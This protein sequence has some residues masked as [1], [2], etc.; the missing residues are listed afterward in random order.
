MNISILLQGAKGSSTAG[1]PARQVDN[2]S[3][4]AAA[5]LQKQAEV[6]LQRAL[7]AQQLAALQAPVSSS[8]D[9]IIQL[10]QRQQQLAALQREAHAFPSESPASSLPF[11]VNLNQPAAPKLEALADILCSHFATTSPA[12]NSAAGPHFVPPPPQ[13]VDDALLLPDRKRKGRAGSFPQ[14]L[15]QILADLQLQQG[16]SDIATFLPHGR[17]FIIHKPREFAQKVL[18][19]YFRMS[20]YSSFQRQLNLYEFQRVADGPDKG[21]YYHPSFVQSRPQWC[22]V[23]KRNK[24]KGTNKSS[25]DHFVHAEEG[26]SHGEGDAGDETS[27]LKE[28]EK[29]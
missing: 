20:Q 13:V 25:N 26:C 2:S 11:P 5:L 10:L 4:L 19:K 8:D 9:I 28:D 21:A 16:G 17:A 12:D 23:M 18:P 7:I 1:P 3:L 6:D 24:I 22:A 27:G 29:Y 14:K 15:H